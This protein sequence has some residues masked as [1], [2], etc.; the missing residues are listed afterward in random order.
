MKDTLRRAF[1]RPIQMACNF[2]TAFSA[3]YLLPDSANTMQW[4]AYMFMWVSLLAHGFDNYNEGFDRGIKF[5]SR[6]E[7]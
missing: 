6:L 4:L 1:G 5:M 3:W 2:T 7:R